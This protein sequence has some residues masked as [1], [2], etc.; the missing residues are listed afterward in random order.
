MAEQ[1]YKAI[2]LSDQ[3]FEQVVRVG[4]GN[5]VRIPVDVLT[6]KAWRELSPAASKVL[7][8]M[9][10]YRNNE[11]GDDQVWPSAETLAKATGLSLSTVYRAQH[12]I[13]CVKLAVKLARGYRHRGEVWQ[14]VIPS[15]NLSP[16]RSSQGREILTGEKFSPA[17]TEELEEVREAEE[18]K[19]ALRSS[20]AGSPP[21]QLP[22]SGSP[23]ASGAEPEEGTAGESNQKYPPPPRARIPKPT[24][25]EFAQRDATSRELGAAMLEVM[26]QARARG[27]TLTSEAQ[28]ERP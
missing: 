10:A 13:A 25:E 7:T 6:S 28:K 11:H 27:E 9:Y 4:M 5:F 21:A 24:P 8:Q 26:R 22:S 1:V 3:P 20:S 15:K 14:L 17:R 23:P 16:A 18:G 2:T 19:T 12:E